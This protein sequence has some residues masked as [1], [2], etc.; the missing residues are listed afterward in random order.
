MAACAGLAALPST[1]LPCLRLCGLPPQ[2]LAAAAPVGTPP[3]LLALH[4]FMCDILEIRKLRDEHSGSPPLFA[5]R[6]PSRGYPMR[7]LV[8]PLPRPEPLPI[9]VCNMSPSEWGWERAFLVDLLLWLAQL[10]WMPPG[11]RHVTFIELAL[12]FEA[13]AGRTSPN[14]A[15]LGARGCS[16]SA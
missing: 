1:W 12:E 13:T 11:V 14:A 3:F 15:V 4:L 10:H 2:S 7:E 9:A 16:I 6:L 8:G 5:S